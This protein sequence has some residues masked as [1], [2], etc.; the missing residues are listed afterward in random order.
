MTFKPPKVGRRWGNKSGR[1]GNFP[2]RPAVRNPPCSAG[3]AG[4]I[5]GRG[6]GFPH[7][8]EQL[9][10]RAAAT[11][12]TCHPRWQESVAAETAA[13]AESAEACNG[14]S[15]HLSKNREPGV[16]Q[17]KGRGVRDQEGQG[18]WGQHQGAL[19]PQDPF[20]FS[21]GGLCFLSQGGEGPG[22]LARAPVAQVSSRLNV[23]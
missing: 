13:R 16:K 12:S 9:G 2:G 14:S 22:M 23:Y 8:V 20:N 15:Q 18:T 6:T 3:D 11:G 5:P 1:C 17:A 10:S 19:A 7:T 4:L 21:C